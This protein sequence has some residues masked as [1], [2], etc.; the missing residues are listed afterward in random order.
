MPLQLEFVRRIPETADIHSFYF[1]PTPGFSFTAGQYLLCTL[2]HEPADDRGTE[3]AFTIASS[4]SERLVRITTRL[5][6]ESSTFKGALMG[7]APG[8]VIEAGGPYGSFS[9]HAEPG[10][11]V[12]IAGGIGITPFRSILGDLAA[13]GDRRDI[14]LLYSSST[15]QIAFRA[16]LDNLA[17]SW[18]GLHVVYTV[19][20]PSSGWDAVTGRIDAELIERYMPAGG[21]TF[22]VCGPTGLVDGIR[23]TLTESGVDAQHVVHESFPG[24][25]GRDPSEAVIPSTVLGQTAR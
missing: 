23:S 11:A 17:I 1:E 12:F 16:F 24:Y 18:P 2:P 25:E 20:R 6:R 21:P 13:S 9:L 15:P 5:S 4:P 22:Y 3:R 10:P 14:T 7:L 8:G 19:T